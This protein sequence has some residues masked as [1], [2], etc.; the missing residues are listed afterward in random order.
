MEKKKKVQADNTLSLLDKLYAEGLP[1]GESEEEV[2]PAELSAADHPAAPAAQLPD[3]LSRL[4]DL[5]M[6]KKPGNEAE[7]EEE[8]AIPS[9]PIIGRN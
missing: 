8:G 5:Q 6:P 1:R 7:L 2:L 4:Q 3:I 9:V